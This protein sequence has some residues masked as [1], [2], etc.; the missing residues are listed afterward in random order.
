MGLKNI[1]SSSIHHHHKTFKIIFSNS[2]D[3]MLELVAK[4]KEENWDLDIVW[5]TP[6]TKL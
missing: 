2:R 1:I 4:A 3:K 6:N 5:V